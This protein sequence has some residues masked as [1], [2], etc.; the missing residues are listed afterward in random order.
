MKKIIKNES[1]HFLEDWKVEFLNENGRAAIY[2][3]LI[4]EPKQQLK[5]VLYEEQYGLCCYCCKSISYPYPNAPDLHIEHFRPKGIEIYKRL[6]LEYDNLHLSCSGYKDEREN[7]G[8]KKDNWFY[9]N[10]T[11]SPLEDDVENLFTYTIDGHIK[12]EDGN[13]RADITISK[14]EL[15]SF[16]LQRLRNRAIHICGLF[17]DDFDEEK[18]K[19]IIREYS[20]PSDGKLK[21]FCNAVIYCVA[22]A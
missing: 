10:L 12:A 3:D 7:C 9:E 6:S 14:L 15:D 18:R 2:S 17:D 13:R 19:A 4:G 22:N 8:H 5:A 11:V 20:T 1:P 21:S 16:A